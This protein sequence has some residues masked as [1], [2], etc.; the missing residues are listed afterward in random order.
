MSKA[1]ARWA[2]SNI[3]GYCYARWKFGRKKNICS[4]VKEG[5]IESLE[6]L[7]EKL[8]SPRRFAAFYILLIWPAMLIS[9]SVKDM[10]YISS[11]RSSVQWM[12]SRCLPDTNQQPIILGMLG[13]GIDCILLVEES[14]NPL[15]DPTVAVRLHACSGTL[16]RGHMQVPV[17]P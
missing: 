3:M 16:G 13:C 9:L 17:F 4:T 1:V 15:K 5:L 6:S 8:W 2:L 12:H 14:F 7:D 11:C 10:H